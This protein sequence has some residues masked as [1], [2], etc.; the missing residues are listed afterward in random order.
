MDIQLLICR[1][2]TWFSAFEVTARK[3]QNITLDA[4]ENHGELIKLTLITAFATVEHELLD[5]F[6]N[7]NRLITLGAQFSKLLEWTFGLSFN[8]VAFQEIAAIPRSFQ[9]WHFRRI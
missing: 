4:S 8:Q 5:D 3:Y 6:S 9:K 2:E 1:L 7:L